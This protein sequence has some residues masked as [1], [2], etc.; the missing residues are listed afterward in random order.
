VRFGQHSNSPASETRLRAVFKSPVGNSAPARWNQELRP[1][2]CTASKHGR[3]AEA[4][5]LLGARHVVF[6]FTMV[7]IGA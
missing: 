7:G 5:Q 6:A 4:W 2:V 3:S 1:F